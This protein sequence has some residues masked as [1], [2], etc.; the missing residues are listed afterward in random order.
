M[1]TKEKT[2]N[3]FSELIGAIPRLRYFCFSVCLAHSDGDNTVEL[4]FGI[5][6]DARY[7]IWSVEHITA[8]PN[9]DGTSS[10]I[11]S[12]PESW[13]IGDLVSTGNNKNSNFSDFKVI[14]TIF[15]EDVGENDGKE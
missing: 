8:I 6:D 13:L 5:K 14:K 15:R 11:P 2:I 10:Y 7:N 9:V 1:E 3:T 4:W 12:I